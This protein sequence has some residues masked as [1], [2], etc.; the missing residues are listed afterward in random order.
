MTPSTAAEPIQPPAYQRFIPET[1]LEARIKGLQIRLDEAEVGGALIVQKADRFYYTGT[2]QQGWLWVPAQGAPLF[3]VFKDPDRAGAESGLA[4]IIPLISPKKIPGTLSEFGAA[5]PERLGL[6]LDVMPANTYLMFK[7]IFDRSGIVDVSDIIRRQRAVKSPFEI[8]CIREAASLA[9]QVAAQVPKLAAQG[10]SEVE[11]AGMVEAHAR[12]LG[13]QGTIT[14]RLWDNHLFYGH[15][16]CG[17]GAAVPGALS[18]PTA[19]VGLNPFVG[20]GP[21]MNPILPGQ[22]LLVDYVFALNGY[23]ADHA[24]IFCLGDLPDDLCRV[25]DHMLEIQEKVKET[26]R[27]GAV[28]GDIYETIKAMAEAKGYKES[29]MGAAAP[30]IRFA[31]HGLGIELDEYPFLAQGQTLLLEEGMTIALEPKVVLP[32]KG[33]VGIENTCLVTGSGLEAL[34]RFPDGICRI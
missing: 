25:H 18:S 12:K 31:G 14:M 16:L 5:L 24:R 29:F 13:H 28:A 22:P 1:E 34:T 17:P 33:V 32:G 21:S 19:G 20:Q 6:E 26:A 9:D 11:L 7:K 2:T 30:R 23:L 10:M 8:A 27:P 4:H 15:I 3:M